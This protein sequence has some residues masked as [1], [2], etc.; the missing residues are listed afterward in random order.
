M[1]FGSLAALGV[2]LL[3]GSLIPTDTL[4]LEMVARGTPNI[5]DL[6]VVLFSVVA[7][8]YATACPKVVAA[9][10]GVA[11]A[12]ALVPP[13]ATVGLALI[14]GKMLVAEGAV[15]LFITNLVAIIVGAATMFYFMGIRS[16]YEN[17]WSLLIL[18][19][20]FLSML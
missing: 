5:M 15:I 14:D 20:L 9:L 17:K 3:L 18:R 1:I 7:A 6:F 10:V 13:Y 8:A 12:A 2:S 16:L 19:R 11:V 4:T